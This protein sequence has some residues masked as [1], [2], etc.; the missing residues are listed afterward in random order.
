MDK[1]TLI[2]LAER[3]E[4]A[5]GPD[6]EL[7]A[8]IAAATGTAVKRDWDADWAPHY[9]ASL[10]AAAA[11]V[12]EGRDWWVRIYNGKPRAAVEHHEPWS[13]ADIACRAATPA[14]ALTAAALRARAAVMEDR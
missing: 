8:E 7:D 1:A 11:L 6:R 10:D 13:W 5:Q 4:K 14:L 2:A 9:C 12:P 3:V